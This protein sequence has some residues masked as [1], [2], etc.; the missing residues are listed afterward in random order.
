M[1]GLGTVEVSVALVVA[2]GAAAAILAFTVLALVAATRRLRAREVR[3]LAAAIEELR[4]G[5]L[6]RK[7][8][9]EPRSPFLPIGESIGRLAQDLAL[10]LAEADSSIQLTTLLSETLR[11]RAVVMTDGDGD[12][13]SVSAGGAVLFG[14]DP[15]AVRGRPVATLFAE[16]SWKDL[17]PRLTRKD[18]REVG[19]D[20][21]GVVR[22]RDGT[23]V[24]VRLA[25]RLVRRGATE[26]SG[27]L[28]V[29]R[30]AE[31]E[32]KLAAELERSESRYRKLV[33]G[34]D[35]AVAIVREGRVLYA[36]PALAALLECD[37]VPAGGI[38]L[39]DRIA[40]SDLLVVK[41]ALAKAEAG[42]EE[43]FRLRA[44]IVGEG[45][46]PAAV[47]RMSIAS[48]DHAGSPAALVSMFDETSARRAEAE[49]RRNEARLDAVLESS[50]DGFAVLAEGPSGA[51]LRMANARFAAL[52]GLRLREILGIGEGDLL[53]LAST[54]VAGGDLL[55]AFLAGAAKGARRET[56]DLGGPEPRVLDA[57][58]LPLVDAEGRVTGRL[59]TLRD[60]SA[61]RAVERRLQEDALE[62]RKGK[63]TLEAAY[64]E[65]A[66]VH[67]DVKKR[68]DDLDRLN[69][70]LKTLDRMKSELL[71]N[72]SHELQTPLVAIRG[73]TEMIL[74]ER[75]GSITEEQRKGLSLSLRNIDRLIALIDELLAFARAE[76]GKDPL[77]PS[78]FP[79]SPLL[80]ETAE[81]LAEKMRAKR[82]SL[83]REV[84]PP[85]LAVRADRDKIL[86]VFVN[87]VSNAVKY[88]REGG[89]VRIAVRRG[90]PGYLEA[91]VRDTGVGIPE[92]DLARIF[93]PF[94][95][96][97]DETAAREEGTGV[98]L[99][100]VKRILR[101]HG[102]AIDVRSREG[103]GTR[104]TFSLPEAGAEAGPEDEP[105]ER[106]GPPR[107]PDPP[108]PS[109]PPA[110]GGR[111]D[112]PRLRIIR[113]SAP[114]A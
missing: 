70:E 22:R 52:L 102:C 29:F 4:S 14:W 13:R 3:D 88:N 76:R 56:L 63:E 75:L 43:T 111:V 114:S 18:L 40:S 78:D 45:G 5:R 50:S 64:A 2:T 53:R 33:E 87:L 65:L 36:N 24:P 57:S 9:L 68:S 19:I 41:E 61:Q 104:F 60:V 96:G 85:D 93:D 35:E 32:A 10:R 44:A 37:P 54:R 26:T 83:E 59:V 55:A 86:Q 71:A 113:R 38:R 84:D 94:E 49:M 11:D 20:C 81:L 47:V 92:E 80:D 98:G 31:E 51:V 17:L 69:G 27:M 15:D 46:E 6:R 74:K 110:N 16:E 30:D 95:R 62:I 105:A 73:Y 12:V 108:G 66:R 106:P 107:P 77:H 67:A 99:S 91:E 103:E 7:I 34:L 97:S 112:G 42:A 109:E 100:I 48:V 101:R 82:V 89:T 39:I 79:V 72:V 23:N 28:F 90:R 21:G 8:D 1:T 58:V 25:I